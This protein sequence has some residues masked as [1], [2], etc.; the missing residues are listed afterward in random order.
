MVLRRADALARIAT[1]ARNRSTSGLTACNALCNDV[2]SWGVAQRPSSNHDKSGSG[3]E[4]TG[5]MLVRAANGGGSGTGDL[6]NDVDRASP[7][8]LGGGR[9]AMES[10]IGPE[11]DSPKRTK[12][13]ACGSEPLTSISSAA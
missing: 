1:A 8:R 12:G 2:F 4:R 6:A 11:N 10:A 7:T 3:R 5:A 13:V 9:A